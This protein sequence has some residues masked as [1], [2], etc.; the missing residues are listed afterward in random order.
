[1]RRPSLFENGPYLFFFL[2]FF[3]FIIWFLLRCTF[4][5]VVA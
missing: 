3:F 2:A 4:S 1:M 5:L